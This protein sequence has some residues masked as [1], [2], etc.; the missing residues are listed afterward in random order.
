M[1]VEERFSHDNL[2]DV[3]STA[4]YGSDWLTMW[5]ANDDE[6]QKLRWEAKSKGMEC[7]EDIWAYVLEHGGRLVCCDM[8]SQEDENDTSC[9]HIIT[10]D[11]MNNGFDIF[12]AKC[13][14]DYADLIDDQ[15]DY[16]TAN[17]LMQCVMFGEVIYG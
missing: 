11:D 4:T 8:E 14:S 5:V 1:Q 16:F 2:V 10:M 17:N 3:F 12:K 7:R 13:P 15:G 6:S 9:Q